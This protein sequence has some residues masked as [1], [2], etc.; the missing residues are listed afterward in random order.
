MI[1]ALIL[2]YPLLRTIDELT[3]EVKR[4]RSVVESHS[5]P[6][7]GSPR[8]TSFNAAAL[9]LPTQDVETT[10][11]LMRSNRHY[12]TSNQISSINQGDFRTEEGIR[13]GAIEET[14]SIPKQCTTSPGELSQP[15]H[16]LEDRTTSRTTTLP[17]NLDGITLTAEQID[18]LFEMY[19]CPTYLK[20]VSSCS[21]CRSYFETYHPFLQILDPQLSP[22]EHYARSPLLFW[23][24]ISLASRRFEEEPT[25]FSALS[26]SVPSMVWSSVAVYPHTRYMIQ[27]IILLC[28]WP[29]PAPSVWTD[30]TLI[31]ISI[32]K[33]A[34]MQIGLHNPDIIKD[35]PRFQRQPSENET[36]EAATIWSA[37]YIAAQWLVD[38][39]ICQILINSR[40][41]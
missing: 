20:P 38:C 36:R 27:A 2:T 22:D 14:P 40:E 17:R 28:M 4:L 3:Q 19:L 12:E 13:L 6:P 1:F 31:L 9:P 16:T 8:E 34:A 25:L 37:C 29:F 15:L 7:L 30:P 39:T 33:N 11:D 18:S 24:I 21:Y 23:S 26:Q 10:S 41:A 32:A 35:F 5:L